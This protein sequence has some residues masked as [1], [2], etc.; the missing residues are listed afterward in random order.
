MAYLSFMGE[1]FLSFIK[2]IRTR[3]NLNFNAKRYFLAMEKPDNLYSPLV[4]I[5]SSTKKQ[6]A[7]DALFR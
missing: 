4:N 3:K 1:S 7:L 6:K 2:Q 5:S